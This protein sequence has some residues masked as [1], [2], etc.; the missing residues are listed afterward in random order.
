M[1]QSGPV[2][3]SR[4][5]LIVDP[6]PDCVESMVAM[7][8]SARQVAIFGVMGGSGV[9]S[10]KSELTPA[11]VFS[12]AFCCPVVEGYMFFGAAE[13]E[14]QLLIVRIITLAQAIRAQRCLGSSVRL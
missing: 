9:L 5:V 13:L 1:L 2:F 10:C 3:P 6:A 4:T 11:S 12:P 8:F 14:L 7:R